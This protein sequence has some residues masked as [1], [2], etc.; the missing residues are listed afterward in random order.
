[1]HSAIFV[2]IGL[3]LLGSVSISQCR[4]TYKEESDGMV[5]GE[6]DFDQVAR[7]EHRY[8][9][10][11][12]FQLM[13][14]QRRTLDKKPCQEILKDT[15]ISAGNNDAQK[16]FSTVTECATYCDSLPNC[17]SF[18]YYPMTGPSNPGQCNPKS[19]TRSSAAPIAGMLAVV[20]DSQQKIATS[21]RCGYEGYCWRGC[22]LGT[23]TDLSGGFGTGN[24]CYAYNK[25]MTET[26]K[27]DNDCS[28]VTPCM[29]PCRPI[30]IA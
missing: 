2:C 30:R 12:L 23:N 18:D 27:T 3:I 21:F 11:A 14:F 7:R 20:C 4:R 22:A 26:C 10:E 24:W 29:L 15:H 5:L 25:N 6:R 19:A 28:G 9:D 16:T 8:D 17:M 1:M 13:G